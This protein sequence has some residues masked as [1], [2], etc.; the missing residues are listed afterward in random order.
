MPSVYNKISGVN[1]SGDIVKLPEALLDVFSLDILH[2][3]QGIMRFEEFAVR[4]QELLA[5]PGEVVKFTIYDDILRSA[6]NNKLDESDSLA[7]QTMAATQKSITVAEWG[8]AIKVSEKLLRLSWD[9]VMAESATL[10]G[11]D[12]AVTR[13]IAL[14]DAL[15]NGVANAIT[16]GNLPAG[17]NFTTDGNI[18]GQV[19]DSLINANETFDIESIR[20]AV[21]ILQT[22]NAPKFF[23]DYY[24]CFLHPHQASYLKRDPDWIN[25]HQY[26]GTRNL[27]N[28]E[29]GRWEDVIF[30]V[31]THAPNG[32]AASSAP[33]YDASLIGDD[34]NGIANN[35]KAYKACVFGDQCLYIADSLPVELRD[36][37]VE[38]FGRTHGLAWYSIFGVDVLK[39]EYAVTITSA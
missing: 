16:A 26:V 33:G 36:N 13:D 2:N 35:V 5:S 39:P 9:D 37:G 6:T 28:G 10:L 7:A 8:N 25:A 14:R 20:N 12:Y 23:G 22:N 21:E 31:T 1:T 18:T 4:R 15:F 19:A 24:V 34:T 30:I 32:A 11:R 3:A 17:H 29:I 38:D 27:F